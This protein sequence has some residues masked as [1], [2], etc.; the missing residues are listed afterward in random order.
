M[1]KNFVQMPR[2]EIHI[3]TQE[4]SCVS[5][6]YYL[7]SSACLLTGLMR[8]ATGRWRLRNCTLTS[9]G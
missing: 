8:S 9:N 2:T 5:T 6:I 7:A 4:V 3:H 1:T